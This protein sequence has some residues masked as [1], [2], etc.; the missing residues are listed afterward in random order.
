MANAGMQFVAAL[1]GMQSK[2]DARAMLAV[3]RLHGKK[4]ACKILKSPCICSYFEH[5]V[6][7]H[8]H[9]MSICAASHRCTA[10]MMSVCGSMA[11]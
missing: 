7:E 11:Q 10:S 6:I 9:L 2:L 1:H 8:E 4:A 5:L 3:S